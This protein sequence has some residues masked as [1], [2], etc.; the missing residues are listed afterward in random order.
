MYNFKETEEK[1][2]KFWEENRIYE[3]R[4]K[5][6][7]KGKK[8]YFLQGPPYTSGKLH[9]GQAW[10]NSMKDIILRYK[11]MQGL[12]VWD[13]GGYDM[14]GLPT[15][16]KVQKDLN[17]A[18]KNAISNYGVEKFIRECIKFST[19]TAQAMNKDLMRLGV[20]LD[21]EHAYMPIKEEFI[22]G[23]WFLI[24]KAWEQN[25]LYK[26]KKIMHWCAS[27]E[28]ALAK[29]E[30][31]YKK[32]KDNSIFLK[33]KHKEKRDEYFI[34]WTTT[35]W[36][37]PFNLAI[38][39]NPQIEYIRAQ[40]ENEVWIIAKALANTV[41]SGV[42]NKKFKVLEEMKGEKL[43]GLEYE[44]PLKDDIDYLL[45]KKQWPKVHTMI[46]S[47]QHVDTSAGSGLVHCAPG[48][49][50]EDFEAAQKYGIGSF[51]SLDEKGIFKDMGIFTG[52]KAK[53]DDAK[54]IKALKEKSA[55]LAETTVEH[56]YAHCWRCKNPIVYRATEQWF[57]KIE[58]LIPELI[59]YNESVYW[60]P[61]F[62]KTNMKIWM[63]NLRDNSI[64]RQRFWGAPVPI[65]TCTQCNAVEVIGS[66]DELKKK[67]GKLPEDL[68]R[69]WID[70]ITFSCIKCKGKM[71]R[72][73]DIIDVWIDSGTT[74]WNCL[75]YPLET[76]YFKEL[77]PANLIL[78]ATEQIRLWF[79]MLQICSAIAF[80][81]SAYK[82][83]YM[84]GM[85]LDFQGTKMSKSL[86][87]VI[88]PYEVIDKYSADI[89]RYYICQTRAGENIN[90]N[91]EDIKTK[92]RNL[93]IL[94]NIAQYL[95]ELG[96]PPKKSERDIEEKYI[97]SRKEKTVKRVTELLEEYRLDEA[98]GEIESLF[99]DIS[100]IYI[101]FTREK[102]L[103][104]KEKVSYTLAEVYIDCLKLF[105]IIA[106]FIAD[107]IWQNLRETFK[108]EES[109]HLA[110]WPK[111]NTQK[112][113]AKL[114]E[115]FSHALKIIELG[116][117]ERDKEKIALKQPLAKAIVYAKQEASKEIE[118]MISDQLNVKSIEWK[119]GENRVEIDTLLTPELEG[120]GFAREI[121]RK[122]QA[123][124]KNALLIKSEKIHLS[125]VCSKKLAKRLQSQSA[126]IK[127]RTNAQE[128]TFTETEHKHYKNT[129]K[130]ELKGEHITILFDKLS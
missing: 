34:I 40:V 46:L 61:K 74:S 99:L 60:W 89:L 66:K 41:I 116:L 85:I 86:G 110:N 84:H 18:D 108:L 32:V 77:Y 17:L 43:L 72:I 1:I 26:G 11:R 112:I 22:E 75:Y 100:R 25:R 73:E 114:E 92:Q 13:R 10:N 59:A 48:C 125:V 21:H 23:E 113:D 30:L 4:K 130:F 37:I 2:L 118:K 16:N 45:L 8:F 93:I 109:V 69:P 20:W 38:M 19:E 82:N 94:M 90:F 79:S 87:N 71:K 95:K 33:F 102:S 115:E 35:P 83:V 103:E 49:G 64:T 124:R 70:G 57:L 29:H 76:K 122:V 129:S 50:P 51:N 65:W 81:K 63:E 31:E 58:D 111:P 88:S 67:A 127:K 128:I 120:E 106:P 5:K 42:M 56:D 123:E 6:N 104:E 24:K 14:H 119:K 47:E 121:A 53:K 91:W 55:L 107:N 36:T 39:V 27:C 3:K 78:E 52:W 98:I 96:Q 97:I 105:S 126:Y 15:E 9:I 80:K 117:A 62:G 68:H 7:E 101:K 54:F 44:H 12:N 28:T